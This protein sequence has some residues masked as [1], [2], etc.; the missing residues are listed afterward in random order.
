MDIEEDEGFLTID[1]KAEPVVEAKA[2]KLH[3][4]CGADRRDGFL[5]VDFRKTSATD[6][7]VD[8]QKTP[9]PWA[10]DSVDVIECKDYLPCLTPQ[11][12]VAFMNE[13]WR[14]LRKD[15]Q[16]T[17]AVPGRGTN[18]SM[19]DP[20]FVWPPVVEDWFYFFSREWREANGFSH[21][22]ITADFHWSYGFVLDDEW[23]PRNEEAQ[24]HAIKHFRNV[25]HGLIVTMTKLSK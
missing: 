20:T 1:A 2:L 12:R 21:Y 22:P 6:E 4:A 8:L 25:T 24:R 9:W 17:I 7:V 19:M 11:K 13:A 23:V 16:M 18:R 3:L 15:G 10:D 14:V 5:N